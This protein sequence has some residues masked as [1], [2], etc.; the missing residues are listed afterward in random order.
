MRPQ[1]AISL[2]FLLA[3]PASAGVKTKSVTYEHGGVKFTGLLAWDDAVSGKRPGVLVVHEVWGLNDYAKKRAEQLAGMGYVA[4]ACDMYGGGKQTSH[5]DDAFKFM[6]EAK[7]N[8][9]VWRGRALAGLQV[10]RNHEAV[11]SSKLAAI[12]YCFG[13][14]TIMQLAQSGADLKVIVSFH[15]GMQP[16]TPEQAKAIKCK[17]MICHGAVDP[18]IPEATMQNI[19]K[20]LDDAKVDYEMIYYGG[21][22]HSFTVPN[23]EKAGIKGLGYNEAADRR[24]W[25]DMR[26]LFS[27]VFK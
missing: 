5:P 13:G 17:V 11:D 3:G 26:D 19:R 9:E 16:P 21:A 14:A 4:F 12:G 15:G 25:R 7:T 10:L 18:L 6:A 2:A 1:L 23:A 8:E 27:E 20:A 24:S 22:L